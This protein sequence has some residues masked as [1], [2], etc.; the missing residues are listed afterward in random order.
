M[1]QGATNAVG[2]VSGEPDQVSMAVDLLHYSNGLYTID[3][4]RALLPFV[5]LPSP[6]WLF[7]SGFP[8]DTFQIH[9][10]TV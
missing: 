2:V 10:R 6:I 5:L 4:I 3:Q 8:N 1:A 9:R 7:F